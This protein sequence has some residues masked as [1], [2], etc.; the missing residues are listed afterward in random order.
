MNDLNFNR[1]MSV[2]EYHELARTGVLLS[3]DPIELLEGRLVQKLT[4]ILKKLNS[5]ARLKAG[6][7]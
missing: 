6:A 3:G 5:S 7:I 1:R 4:P 2:A